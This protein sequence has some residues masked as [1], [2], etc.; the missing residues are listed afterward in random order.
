MRIVLAAFLTAAALLHGIYIGYARAEE[1]ASQSL[2]LQAV[3]HHTYLNNPSLKAVRAGLEAKREL[4]PQAFAGWKPTVLSEANLTASDVDGSNFGGGDGSTSKDV[5]VSLDQPLFRGGRTFAGI[6]AARHTI[7]AQEEFLRAH[8]QDVLLAATTA[9]MDVLRDQGLVDL[10][11]GTRNVISKEL[12][13][14]QDR[15]EVG[16]LTKTDVSQARARLARANSDVITARGNLNSSTAVFEEIVGLPS[17]DLVSPV[18]NLSLPSN[19][20]EAIAQADET[21]PVILS[22]IH[23][24]RSSEEGVDQVFG[25]LLP[26]IGLFSSWNKTFDPSPG[27][28][29]EQTTKLIGISASIPLYQ[30]GA[31]RSRVREAKKTANQKYMEVLEIKREVRQNVV[32]AWADWQAAQAEIRSR[33]VQIEASTVAQEGVR[34]EMEFGSRTVLDALDADQELLDAQVALL[35]AQRNEVVAKFSLLSTLGLL[36]PQTTGF[37]EDIIH[38]DKN[39]G[40]ITEKILNMDVDRVQEVD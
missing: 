33:K 5:G 11:L 17:K 21:S 39:S 31:V 25:E 1:K 12:E 36:A 16:E 18:L 23:T 26:E 15:F 19:L 38:S 2:T 14:T 9:Y 10:S 7:Q 27:L 29:E 40:D 6:S 30:A 8:E 22:A 35:T 32:G 3:L 13:V 34:H 4:L 37:T 20:D 24:H 28:I